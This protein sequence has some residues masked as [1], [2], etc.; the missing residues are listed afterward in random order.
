MTTQELTAGRRLRNTTAQLGPLAVAGAM[1]VGLLATGCAREVAVVGEGAVGT[2]SRATEPFTSIE[3]SYGIGVTIQIGPAAPLEVSAQQNLLPIVVTDVQGG[4]LRIRGTTEFTTSE[5]PNVTIVTP[6]LVGISLSGGSRG[7]IEGL[8]SEILAIELGGGS[9][10]TATGI[11]ANIALQAGGSSYATLEGLA[12]SAVVIDLSG[13]SIVNLHVSGEVIG[14]ASGGS[15]ATISGDAQIS[16]AS[17]G[18]AVVS[19]G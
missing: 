2:E 5:T 14:Q 4:T 17:S 13:A 12:A 6:S 9:E 15:R 11:A 8:N 1:L 7:R 16:V 3:V 18:G 10:L 19:R